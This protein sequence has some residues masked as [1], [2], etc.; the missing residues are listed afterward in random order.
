MAF[1]AFD[2]DE[3]LGWCWGYHLVRPDTSSMLY[4]HRLEVTPERR[5][6]GTGRALLRAFMSAGVRA[7]ATRMFMTTGEANA[8]ARALYESMGGGP[9]T[10]GPTV[11]YWFPLQ[12]DVA[13]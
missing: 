8:A 9:A 4:L 7:G 12:P 6:R 5:R 13:A 10:Q 11:N 1:V 3:I 2:G